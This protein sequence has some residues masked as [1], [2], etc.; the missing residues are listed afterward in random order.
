MAALQPPPEAFAA[1]SAHFGAA[2]FRPGQWRAIAAALE[3]RDSTVFLPT[4]AGKSL[5]FQMPALLRDGLVLVVSPLLALIDDQ[6]AALR[7]RGVRAASIS[8]ARSVA[9]NRATL[10]LLSGSPPELDLLYLAPETAQNRKVSD[11]LVA[12][13][14]RRQ[15][16]LMA[17]D[18]AHCIVSWGHDFRPAFLRLAELR[19]ALPGVPVMALSATATQPVRAAI[20]ERLR[21]REPVAV[22]SRFDRGEIF[23]EVHLKEAMP[24]GQDA[25]THL[26]ASLRQREAECGIV[27]CATREGTAT[28]AAQ[29]AADRVTAGAYHAGLS[30]AQREATQQ[31]W[32]SGALRV[33]VATV[34]FGMGIDKADVRFVVHWSLPTSFEDYYQESGRA[35][36]DGKPA[37]ST[38]YFSEEDASTRR[39]IIRKSAPASRAASST[40][41]FP[42][43]AAAAA[44]AAAASSSSCS[45]SSSRSVAAATGANAPSARDHGLERRLAAVDEVVTH[46]LLARGCRRQSVL[47]H[48]GEERLPLA[49]GM[50]CCDLCSKPKVVAEAAARYSLLKL[51]STGSSGRGGR[52]GGALAVNGKRSRNDP[53]NT[54]L[55]DPDSESEG[56]G[57]AEEDEQEDV[58]LPGPLAK[59]GDR[60]ALRRRLDALEAREALSSDRPG[61][62][63]KKSL[64]DRLR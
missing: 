30:S 48:F 3:S 21:L 56:E 29:L 39:F 36:R 25:Y 19:A 43:T 10:A 5:C 58:S 6:V 7:R 22:S 33:I 63:P 57:S 27:Y 18:E 38:I 60:E 14:R 34:A 45:S 54:G 40:S 64:R 31:Q 41:A 62:K 49:S 16:L 51:R 28:L 42:A 61:A 46:C 17:V 44:A 53:H 59:R 12:L 26:L 23:Y 4:G 52:G 32:M 20:A 11:E 9:E 15:L 13:A 24:R 50:V 47:A 8:S 2:R 55:V 37:T 1:L 35:A